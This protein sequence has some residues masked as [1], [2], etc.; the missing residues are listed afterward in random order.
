MLQFIV[1]ATDVDSIVFE[2]SQAL[3]GGC[4]WIEIKA[5]K[6]VSDETVREAV[7]RLKDSVHEVEGILTL[8]ERVELAKELE[9]DGVQV[10]M[11]DIKVASAREVLEAGP[12]IGVSVN[13]L[14]EVRAVAGADFDF[15][16]FEPIVNTDGTIRAQELEAV[17]QFLKDSGSELPLAAAG[18]VT[19]DN[20]AE[21]CSC[22]AV[23][24]A[25]D[26]SIAGGANLGISEAVRELL[27]RLGV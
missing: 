23:G 15:Y 14:A 3:A 19:I 13:N 2:A 25:V 12:I 4:R 1:T 5:P 26:K 24:V 16:R 21:V 17:A 10:A 20:L 11:A 6:E 18:G 9:V 22:G 27:H 7:G 8:W